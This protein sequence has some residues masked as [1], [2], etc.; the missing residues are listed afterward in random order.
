MI[1]QTRA[2]IKDFAAAYEVAKD[3][4]ELVS[5]MTAQYPNHGNLYGPYSSLPW[6]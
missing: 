5:A 1:A 4:D 2:Y 6:P 3:T